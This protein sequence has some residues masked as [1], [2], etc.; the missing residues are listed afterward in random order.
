MNGWEISAL[1]FSNGTGKIKNHSSQCQQNVGWWKKGFKGKSCIFTYSDI[2]L[3]HFYSFPSESWM[4]N[5]Q[6]AL[7]EFPAAC[8]ETFQLNYRTGYWSILAVSTSKSF[9]AVKLYAYGSRKI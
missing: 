4:N 7:N 6:F 9:T 8:F 5:S 1:T 2:P 3:T